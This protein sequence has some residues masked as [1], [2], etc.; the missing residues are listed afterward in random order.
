M[1]NYNP[2]F[3]VL[4]IV[5]TVNLLSPKLIAMNSTI[6]IWHYAISKSNLK[7]DGQA[8]DGALMSAKHLMKKRCESVNK[9]CMGKNRFGVVE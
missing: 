8:Y 6:F 3:D 2:A 9:F 7:T 4:L 5:Y 1:H